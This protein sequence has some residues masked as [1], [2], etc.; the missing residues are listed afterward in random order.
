MTRPTCADPVP[1]RHAL[2]VVLLCGAS[3]TAAPGPAPEDPAP[4]QAHLQVRVGG[5]LAWARG[6]TAETLQATVRLHGDAIRI[7]FDD[8]PDAGSYLLNT[9]TFGRGWIVNP[10]G[11][12]RLP[13]ADASGPYWLD[14]Q[15]PCAHIGGRCSPAHGEFIAG[16]LARGWRYERAD[17]GPDGTT[18]G[19]LWVDTQTGLLLGYRGSAGNG[20]RERTLRVTAV[21]FE[22]QPRELF[23]LPGELRSPADR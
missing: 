5:A 23:E 10:A 14:P 1:W 19:T 11:N 13:I 3:A 4:P 17:R 6:N 22:P 12:Y 8:G 7:E 16:R 15:Q 20:G 21:G 18:R 2:L 9:G